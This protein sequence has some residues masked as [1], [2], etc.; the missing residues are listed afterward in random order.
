MI[1][2]PTTLEGSYVI[3][4]EQYSDSRG[5]FARFFCKKEF[6][7]IGH[8]KEWVQL[9]HSANFRQGTLRGMHFQCPPFREIKMVRCIAGSVFDVIVDLRKESKTFMNWY[10]TELSATNRKMLYIPEGF[11][12]GFQTLSDNSE[13]IYHHTEFYTAGSEGGIRYNDPRL[14]IQWPLSVSIISDRD[15]THPYLD[16]HFKGI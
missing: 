9:N 3:D 10:G 15:K 7:A 13:L 8:D 12:H 6:S 11:A 5:W 4:I 2:T 16:Q 14:N 1:F